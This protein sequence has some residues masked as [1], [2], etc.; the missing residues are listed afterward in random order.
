MDAPLHV[1]SWGPAP[2][3]RAVLAVHG[4]TGHGARWRSLAADHL[5]D[6]PVLAPDLRGHGHSPSLPPWTL[7]QHATDLLGVL[8]AHDVARAVVVGHSFG[9]AIAL[10][11]A[12]LA[13]DRVESLVLLDPAAALRPEWALHAAGDWERPPRFADPAAARAERTQAWERISAAEVDA[14]VEAHL[15]Q[16][17]D[18]SWGWRVCVPAVMAAWSEMARPLPECSGVPTEVVVAERMDPE[19]VA[20]ALAGWPAVRVVRWDCGH[21]VA[22]ELPARTA[23]LVREVWDRDPGRP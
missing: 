19:I 5:A 15:E 11:L 8:D 12:V 10:R 20:P 21:N 16:R 1:Q 17:A 9:G 6:L 14:E 22:L 23:A 4:V 3:G 7:E 13:P 18:G 2:D